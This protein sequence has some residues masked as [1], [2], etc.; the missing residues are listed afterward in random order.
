MS[1]EQVARVREMATTGASDSEIG[2]ELGVHARTVLRI[3]QQHG[4]PSAWQPERK[5]CGTAASY[6]RGCRCQVCR[7]AN[8]ARMAARRTAMRARRAAGTA[9]FEHGASGY[10]NWGCRCQ[11]CCEGHAARMT[12]NKARRG[13]R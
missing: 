1:P 12:A 13:A 7:R 4:I 2:A 10:N 3:R 6:L 5:P 8:A 9:E 11:I